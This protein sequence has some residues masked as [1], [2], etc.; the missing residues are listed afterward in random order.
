MQEGTQSYIITSSD[1]DQGP[2]VSAIGISSI[3]DNRCALDLVVD[4]V[5]T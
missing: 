4:S 3:F 2:L 1:P 5:N